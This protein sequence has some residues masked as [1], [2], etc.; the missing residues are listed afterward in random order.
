MTTPDK[1]PLAGYRL[2][3]VYALEQHYKVLEPLD[4]ADSAQAEEQPAPD[5]DER[6]FRVIWD[7]QMSDAGTFAVFLGIV[8]EPTSTVRE[9]VRVGMI[10]EF[11]VQVG[12][13]SLALRPFVQTSAPAILF[14]Y[15]RET[16]QSLTGRGP[17]GG[18]T[19]PPI[20][21]M[22]MTSGYDF[23]GTTGAGQ[24][25]ENPELVGLAEPSEQ[26]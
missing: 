13:P 21:V 4:A 10:G 5:A 11:A 6:P 18:W 3:Q 17:F 24:I 9:E 2:L 16:I 8:V 15:L 7:W 22:A 12:T 26:M 20:N 14:P 23:E 25:R 1:P 19:V